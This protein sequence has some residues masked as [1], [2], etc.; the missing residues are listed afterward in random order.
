MSKPED[1]FE[2]WMKNARHRK[3]IL[4]KSFREVG[5]GMATGEYRGTRDTAIYTADFGARQR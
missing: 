1:R 3:N 4:E 2:A 5:V